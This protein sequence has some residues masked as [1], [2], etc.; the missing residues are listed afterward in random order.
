MARHPTLYARI[1]DGQYKVGLIGWSQLVPDEA[2]NTPLEAF[3]R[4]QKIAKLTGCP[5]C[6]VLRKTGRNQ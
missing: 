6:W 2:F 4:L 1:E 3:R 5:T